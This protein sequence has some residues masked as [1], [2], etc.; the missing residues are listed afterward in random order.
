MELWPL[1]CLA[2]LATGLVAISIIDFR[3]GYLPDTLQVALAIF[4]VAIVWYGS[5]VGITWEWSVLGMLINGAVFWLLRWLISNLKGR[6]S[7]GLGDVKLVAV[8]GIWLG[9]FALP[10]IMAAGGILTLLGAGVATFV[11]GKPIW[12][13]EMP[14]GPGLATGILGVFIAA[15]FQVPWLQLTY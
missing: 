2:A 9:P 3:T 5:P 11:T 6:E 13:G 12:R 14:L 8:G 4:G 7:M 15:L 10:Y 1:I